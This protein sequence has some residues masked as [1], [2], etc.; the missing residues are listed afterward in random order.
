P[1]QYSAVIIQYNHEWT[2]INTNETSD[3]AAFCEFYFD[4]QMVSFF[5]IFESPGN[6]WLFVL[7]RFH[8]WFLSAW[9]R[10]RAKRAAPMKFKASYI[11][12]HA[13]LR[14]APRGAFQF[15]GSDRRSPQ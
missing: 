12:L 11:P 7:I 5:A 6:A 9:I 8:S 3:N 4:H 13:S 14:N 1:V 2:R 10:L 15:F